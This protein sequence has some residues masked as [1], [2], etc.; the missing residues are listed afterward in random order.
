MRKVA[1]HSNALVE[2]FYG[3]AIGPCAAVIKAQVLMHK[4]AN[5]LNASPA[6][7]GVAELRPGKVEQ[8]A[9]YFTVAAWQ[10]KLQRLRG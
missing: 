2:A 5:G 6:Q 10:Q 7:S 1:A 9:V 8:R 4:V 3:T